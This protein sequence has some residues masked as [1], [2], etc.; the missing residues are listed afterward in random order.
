MVKETHKI[1]HDDTIEITATTVRIPVFY[2]HSE[3]IYIE[4]EKE[5]SV[6][7]ITSVLKDAQGVSVVDN[8]SADPPQYP[9][10][11]FAEGKDD[12]YVGRIRKD[13]FKENGINMWVV[14]DNIR[15]GAA[16][17]A[18]QIAEELIR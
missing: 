2:A 9:M 3:S 16:L 6:E 11:I 13:P 18:V 5:L 17:N 15:K 8:I 14:S 1:L 4:T 7:E 10:P 12:T